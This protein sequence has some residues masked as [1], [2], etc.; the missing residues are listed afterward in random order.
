MSGQ[1]RTQTINTCTLNAPTSWIYMCFTVT[2]G[3]KFMELCYTCQSSAARLRSTSHHPKTCVRSRRRRMVRTPL[4]EQG[5]LMIILRAA[6]AKFRRSMVT[7]I[8][9]SPVGEA[10]LC[11]HMHIHARNANSLLAPH[12]SGALLIFPVHSAVLGHELEGDILLDVDILASDSVLV[13]RNGAARRISPGCSGHIHIP[14]TS[15]PRCP[16]MA[17]GHPRRDVVMS[18]TLC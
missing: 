15:A 8:L 18:S 16:T 4:A 2:C 14:L 3:T 7:R 1:R 10:P 17:Q 6:R 9:I 13:H 12:Q 5:T 11:S